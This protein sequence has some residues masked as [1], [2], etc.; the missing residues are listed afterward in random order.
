MPMLV[1]GDL[2]F[3]FVNVSLKKCKSCSFLHQDINICITSKVFSGRKG[4]LLNII[5]DECWP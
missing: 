5:D 2:C 1:L 3:N 4:E